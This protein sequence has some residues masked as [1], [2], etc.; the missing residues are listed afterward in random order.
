M[1]ARFL[2]GWGKGKNHPHTH[3]FIHPTDQQINQTNNQQ[4][5]RQIN[6][7][8][9]GLGTEHSY[10]CRR[11]S[12]LSEDHSRREHLNFKKEKGDLLGG[13]RGMFLV[14]G[15]PAVL[16]PQPLYC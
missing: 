16:I 5:T 3:P 8:G 11:G 15:A 13:W 12:W 1:Q 7:E 6:A 10:F 14:T 4:P 2:R 9:P